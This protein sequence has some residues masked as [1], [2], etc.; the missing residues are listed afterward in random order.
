LHVWSLQLFHTLLGPQWTKNI[1][2]RE[3][4]HGANAVCID[5]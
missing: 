1:A 3:T 4:V 2:F 5:A